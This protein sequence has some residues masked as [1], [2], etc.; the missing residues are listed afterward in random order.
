MGTF[1]KSA[2]DFYNE[3]EST[4]KDTD[5]SEH[6]FIYS[7][8]KPVA[9]ELSYMSMILDEIEKKIHAKSALENGYDEDLIQ[10]CEDFGIF[11]NE[12]QKATG[13][14]KITG[15]PNSKLPANSIVAT[16]SGIS[17][18]TDSD[19]V[20]DSDGTVEVSITALEEGAKYN[21]EAN[22]IV[23]F[24]IKYEGILTVTNEKAITNG[25]DIEELDHLYQRYKERVS[26]VIVAGNVEWYK[27][28]AREIIGVGDVKGYECMDAN[29]Q[30]KNG[31]V[32]LI[33]TDVNR[34]KASDE[35][36]K[37]VSD[38]IEK[39]RLAGA[40]INIVSAKELPI[41]ID[42]DIVYNSK[43]T[44][45]D[46]IKQEIEDTIQDYFKSLDF[47]TEYVSVYKINSI[48]FNITNVIDVR[49]IKLNGAEANVNISEDEIP[50][51]NNLTVG[52]V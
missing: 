16:T 28:I 19:V 39:I 36:I 12:A 4:F 14:V 40:K 52:V 37:E 44:T 46:E 15:N 1:Y 11:R 48:I 5:N 29:K 32:L 7:A 49:S 17:Y 51:F 38:Y 6:S 34:R 23:S 20:I 45:E 8:N 25:Y 33:I 24:P 47:K 26:D 41:D 22:K 27:T 35:L 30:T 43:V 2:E 31:N 42:V 13:I 10:R 50:I 21:V 9:F 18:V 3:M